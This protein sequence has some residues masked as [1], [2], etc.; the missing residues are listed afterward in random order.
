[1][2]LSQQVP[3]FQSIF[4]VVVTFLLSTQLFESTAARSIPTCKENSTGYDFVCPP[5]L[6]FHETFLTCSQIVIGGGTAGLALATR[7]SQRLDDCVLVIEAG[8]SGLTEPNIYIPGLRG[9]TLE[10]VYDWNLTTVPQPGANGCAWLQNRG[11]V[12]GGSSALNL[13]A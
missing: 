8:P 7:L 1:M 2:I 5:S 10:S 12:M 9:S 13:I 3:M 4:S 6:S 11:K